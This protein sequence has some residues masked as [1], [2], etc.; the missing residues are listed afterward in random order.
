MSEA[1]GPYE[2]DHRPKSVL[3]RRGCHACL[4][5][6]GFKAGRSSRDGLRK[7]L[8]EAQQFVVDQIAEIG[9]CDHSVGH[10][11]CDVIRLAE[12][13][14]EALEADGGVK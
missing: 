6:D 2:H 10:C 12:N 5:E 3:T 4:W 14:K 7:A 9:S 1:K 11:E 8:E 13:I